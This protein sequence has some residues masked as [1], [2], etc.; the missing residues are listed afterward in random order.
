MELLIAIKLHP[1]VLIN[2]RDLLLFKGELRPRYQ[3]FEI[4]G[5]HHFN[6]TRIRHGIAKIVD[7]LRYTLIF[8][9]I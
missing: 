6:L 7:E 4:N 1:V 3:C 5:V 8:R 2:V 9:K